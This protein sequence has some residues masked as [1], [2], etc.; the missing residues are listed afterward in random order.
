MSKNF[1]K[2]KSAY[3]RGSYTKKMVRALVPKQITEEEYEMI[4]GEKF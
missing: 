2:I 3:D 1:E 4:T